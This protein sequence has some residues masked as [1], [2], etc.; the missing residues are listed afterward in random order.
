MVVCHGRF[1]S[2]ITRFSHF[3]MMQIGN[4]WPEQRTPKWSIL[5]FF[6]SFRLWLSLHCH[7][8]IRIIVN[9]PSDVDHCRSVFNWLDDGCM[10]VCHLNASFFCFGFFFLSLSSTSSN[11]HG[12]TRSNR[13]TSRA[14]FR[15][16]GTIINV[17]CLAR[18]Q[19]AFNDAPNKINSNLIHAYEFSFN[20]PYQSLETPVQHK[21]EEEEGIV[22]N[23]NTVDTGRF[24]VLVAVRTWSQ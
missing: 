22:K 5:F 10:L 3:Y 14:S 11:L 21:N 12:K 8:H 13:K 9:L 24:D 17:A 4:L 18:N 2:N 16:H 1:I 7:I 20:K 6:F 23:K 19:T 15:G